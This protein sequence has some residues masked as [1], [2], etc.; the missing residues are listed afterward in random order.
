MMITCKQATDFISKKEEGKLTL[1]QRYQLRLHTMLCI[2]CRLFYRQNKVMITSL[3]NTDSH[4]HK[5][6]EPADKAA[7][8]KAMEETEA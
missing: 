2:L 7:F 8:I 1:K 4:G 3:K 6:L 5:P